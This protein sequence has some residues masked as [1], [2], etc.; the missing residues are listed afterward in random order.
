M[1]LLY[2]GSFKFK[3]DGLLGMEAT[4][5]EVFDAVGKPGVQKWV[6]L[7]LDIDVSTD[8]HRH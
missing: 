6:V 4:Q 1:V 7:S 2:T 3:F 5:E 8:P